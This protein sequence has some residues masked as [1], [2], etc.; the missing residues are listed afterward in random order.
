M[1]T[2]TTQPRLADPAVYAATRDAFENG[3]P[4][5]AIAA[6]LSVH[7][8]TVYKW[9]QIHGWSRKNSLADQIA[10]VAAML[11][12]GVPIREISRELDIHRNTIYAWKAHGWL[13]DKP[14]DLPPA[15]PPA[16]THYVGYVPGS[17]PGPPSL[18]PTE[19]GGHW[20]PCGA[21]YGN[22]QDLAAHKKAG[23]HLYIDAGSLE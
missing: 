14:A 8:T 12:D 22:Q 20:C 4:V 3:T 7:L 5:P 16:G 9:A 13:P 17:K 18:P 11:A 19:L 23:K 21:R 15:R 1:T 10:E 6:R 2:L